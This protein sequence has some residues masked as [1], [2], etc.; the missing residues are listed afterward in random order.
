MLVNML[1]HRILVF[2]HTSSW[3][4][5][6]FDIKNAWKQVSPPTDHINRKAIKPTITLTGEPSTASK[7]LS[8][9]YDV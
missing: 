9:Q 8:L 5:T 2:E 1:A 4:V 7:S 6:P 3:V